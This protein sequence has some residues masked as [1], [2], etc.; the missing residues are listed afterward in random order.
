MW[1]CIMSMTNVEKKRIAKRKSKENRA[2]KAANIRRTA[3]PKR[4]RLDVEIDGKW[5]QGVMGFRDVAQVDAHRAR[6]EK[7]R[8]SG[9]E[10]APGRVVDTMTGK[11]VVE[12]RG[13][14]I[15]GELPDMVTR[16]FMEDPNV[17]AMPPEVPARV[18]IVSPGYLGTGET[19]I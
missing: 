17:T 14:R 11:V 2:R 12:I 6:T 4:F 18:E 1:R 7:R 16:G 10:I 19:K 5:M 3:A 15:K 13:S 8:M 9:D